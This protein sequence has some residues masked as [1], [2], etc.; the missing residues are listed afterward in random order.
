MLERRTKRKPQRD[1]PSRGCP[2]ECTF[3][4][5]IE[6]EPPDRGANLPGLPA[7]RPSVAAMHPVGAQYGPDTPDVAIQRR[8][9]AEVTVGRTVDLFMIDR[10]Q[11]T[12]KITREG[13]AA[14]YGPRIPGG[15]QGLTAQLSRRRA[16]IEIGERHVLVHAVLVDCIEPKLDFAVARAPCGDHFAGA[17]RIEEIVG[18]Q[19][20]AKVRLHMSEAR[21]DGAHMAKVFLEHSN[22]LVGIGLDDFARTIRRS[23]VHNNDLAHWPRLAKYALDRPRDVRTVVV[24]NYDDIDSF[25][26]HAKSPDLRRLNRPTIR[27]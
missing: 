17:V 24:I 27:Q 22:D 26:R 15:L 12:K 8:Q 2:D 18:V 20:D 1:I 25:I 23:V 14:G 13:A 16:G 10:Q 11:L 19:E 5:P 3:Q 6:L 4:R 21:I 9:L 7:S